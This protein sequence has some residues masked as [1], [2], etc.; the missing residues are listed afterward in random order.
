MYQLRI[1]GRGGQGG[2]TASRLI[3]T[4]AFLEGKEAQDFSVYGAERRGAPVVS[5]CRI[6]T[7]PIL[8][9]GYVHEP[10]AVIILD[11]TIIHVADVEH[12]IAKDGIILMN[13]SKNPEDFEQDFHEQ[14]KLYTLDATKIAL[15]TISRPI[16]NAT[17]LGA[18]IKLTNLVSLDSLKKA[19]DKEVHVSKELRDKNIQSAINC[20]NSIEP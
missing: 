5:F 13:S 16:P 18:F 14:A 2:K 15:E 20:Y 4:A 17:I 3:G 9:R 8:I 19:I 1:H 11:D 6:D 10:D 7:K 12:G